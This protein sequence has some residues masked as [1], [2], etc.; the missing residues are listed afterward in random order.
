MNSPKQEDTK[1]ELKNEL[2]FYAIHWT[3]QKRSWENNAISNS[4]KKNKILGNKPNEE[5]KDFYT[6]N[7]KLLL[8][9]INKDTNRKTFYIYELDDL[10]C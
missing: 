3:I 1:P 7:Y 2:H 8:K 10:L 4:V 9:E 6:K 5:E